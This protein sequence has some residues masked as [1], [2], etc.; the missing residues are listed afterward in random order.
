M[1]V[2][3]TLWSRIL[4]A[5]LITVERFPPIELSAP[6][7]LRLADLLGELESDATAAHDAYVSG[8]PRGPIT[9]FKTLDRELGGA[10]APGIHVLHASPGVGK[11][12]LAFQIA[13]TC[14]Y[15]ALFIT[16]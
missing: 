5:D 3:A 6:R 2:P 11:S 13:A 14:E 12:A 1:M 9:T 4:S 15:P 7:L 16:C 8:R 10:L